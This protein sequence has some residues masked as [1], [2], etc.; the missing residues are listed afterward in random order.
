MERGEGV[1]RRVLEPRGVLG[2][3]GAELEVL[4]GF[5]VVILGGVDIWGGGFALM[6]YLG[7]FKA[8]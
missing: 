1:G 6:Y 4:G 3:Y 8:N 7:L 5:R 2:G